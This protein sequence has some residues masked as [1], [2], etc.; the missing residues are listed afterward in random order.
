MN[1]NNSIFYEILEFERLYKMKNALLESGREYMPAKFWIITSKKHISQLKENYSEEKT[2]LRIMKRR[3]SH[4]DF[5]EATPKEKQRITQFFRRR[6]FSWET[7]SRV[8]MI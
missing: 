7:I 4:F 8:L 6:G 3:F 2:A 5:H 1:E